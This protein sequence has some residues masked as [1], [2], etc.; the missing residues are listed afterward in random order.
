MKYIKVFET[1]A[2]YEAA[3]ET[4]ETPNVSLVIENMQWDGKGISIKPAESDDVLVASLVI[5]NNKGGD[6]EVIEIFKND[7]EDFDNEIVLS[8]DVINAFV[9]PYEGAKAPVS[10]ANEIH[11]IILHGNSNWNYMVSDIAFKDLHEMA[12]ITLEG[13]KRIYNESGENQPFNCVNGRLVGVVVPDGEK[14]T[15]LNNWEND[16]TLVQ[17]ASVFDEASVEYTVEELAEAY[18]KEDNDCS[19]K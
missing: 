6:D 17:P 19:G 15:Y 2:D 5:P 11:H 10:R 7:L 14:Q 8:Y 9:N 4:L 3:E 12:F 13:Y 1:Q 16:E 18:T